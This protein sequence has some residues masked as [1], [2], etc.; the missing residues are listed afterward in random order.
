MSLL[1]KGGLVLAVEGIELLSVRAALLLSH[2]PWLSLSCASWGLGRIEKEEQRIT[3]CVCVRT[4]ACVCGNVRILSFSLPHFHTGHQHLPQPSD[5]PL[6]L[7]QLPRRVLAVREPGVKVCPAISLVGWVTSG[8]SLDSLGTDIFTCKIKIV[9][10]TL[11][12][13]WRCDE[14]QIKRVTVGKRP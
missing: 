12:I 2:H 10:P 3:V 14:D 11:P 1:V 9:S 8:R 5:A 6:A 13:T 4:R 7:H